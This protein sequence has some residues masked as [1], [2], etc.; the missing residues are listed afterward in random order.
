MPK[1][2]YK[3]KGNT[4]TIKVIKKGYTVT[5]KK[6]GVTISKGDKSAFHR[7]YHTTSITSLRKLEKRLED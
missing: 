2:I 1:L 6:T 3:N 7:G 4:A 5:Q